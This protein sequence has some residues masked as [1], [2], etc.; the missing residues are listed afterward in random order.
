MATQVAVPAKGRAP[1]GLKMEGDRPGA[2]GPFL[3][4]EIILFVRTLVMNICLD[5]FILCTSRLSHD[6][7]DDLSNTV[8]DR[9]AK[10]RLAILRNPDNMQIGREDRVRAFAVYLNHPSL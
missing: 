5:H 10:H 6:A 9:P 7:T 3:D 1:C 2:P 8:P 4:L